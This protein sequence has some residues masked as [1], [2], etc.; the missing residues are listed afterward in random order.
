MVRIEKI[1]I[2]A[3]NGSCCRDSR[4]PSYI[5]FGPFYMEK[6]G[7]TVQKNQ[8]L[9][10]ITFSNQKKSQDGGFQLGAK[11]IFSCFEY[12]WAYKN[13]AAK[14]STSSSTARKRREKKTGWQ[15][16]FHKK[17]NK[18]SNHLAHFV[19]AHSNKNNDLKKPKNSHSFDF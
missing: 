4:M 1:D 6:H 3:L 2:W 8:C 7:Q 9:R 12:H 5:R 17:K 10:N 14:R 19:T 11:S 13:S 18:G 15:S 16:F